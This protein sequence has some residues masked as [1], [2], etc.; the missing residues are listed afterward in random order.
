MSFF[1]SFKDF[2]KD[3]M[4]FIRK[5]FLTKPKKNKTISSIYLEDEENFK[6][7]SEALPFLKKN[8]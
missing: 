4:G 6:P 1:K 3:F 2:I 8:N 5:E 7:R